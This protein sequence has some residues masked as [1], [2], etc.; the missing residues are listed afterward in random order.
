MAAAAR[1]W[2]AL[3]GVRE[4]PPGPRMDPATDA[5]DVA[6]VAAAAAAAAVAAETAAAAGVA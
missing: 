3:H 2:T 5:S 1:R 4:P 6:A